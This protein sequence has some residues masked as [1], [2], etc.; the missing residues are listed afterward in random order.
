M[1][2]YSYYLTIIPVKASIDLMKI[3]SFSQEILQENNEF[4]RNWKNLGKLHFLA[5]LLPIHLRCVAVNPQPVV[6][7]LQDFDQQSKP[8]SGNLHTKLSR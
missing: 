7:S 5:S 4:I 2:S 6:I 3:I 1:P 8:A